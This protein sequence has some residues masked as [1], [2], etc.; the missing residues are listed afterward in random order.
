MPCSLLS[1][2]AVTALRISSSEGVPVAGMPLV[3]GAREVVVIA[4][5]EV[6]AMFFNCP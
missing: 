6:V 4:V 2:T 1:M 3:P 5:V